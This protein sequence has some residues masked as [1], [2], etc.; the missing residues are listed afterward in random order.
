MWT[1]AEQDTCQEELAKN[2]TPQGPLIPLGGPQPAGKQ[3]EIS[4][5]AAQ[6]FLDV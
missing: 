1:E 3:S 5:A 2:P 6:T 4:D